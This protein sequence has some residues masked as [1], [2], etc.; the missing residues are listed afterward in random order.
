[1]QAF[2]RLVDRDTSQ[3]LGEMAVTVTNNQGLKEKLT[4]TC[5]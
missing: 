3:F 2:I 5:G 1:M 4:D